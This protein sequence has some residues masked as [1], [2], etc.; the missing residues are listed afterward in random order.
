MDAAMPTGCMNGG[1]CDGSSGKAVCKCPKKWQGYN[2]ETPVRMYP[3]ISLLYSKWQNA[4]KYFKDTCYTECQISFVNTQRIKNPRG[5]FFF[6]L[7][8]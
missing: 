4:V 5:I 2:C 7:T 1:T 3:I 6:F 8:F